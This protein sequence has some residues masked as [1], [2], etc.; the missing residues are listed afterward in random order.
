MLPKIFVKELG[1]KLLKMD[2]N[3]ENIL[4]TV[5][6]YKSLA[7]NPI[8]Q[9]VVVQDITCLQFLAYILDSPNEEVIEEAL[10][11]FK[12][13]IEDKSN[14][15]TLLSVFGVLEAL[16]S[17]A[18]RC[19]NDKLAATARELH[20]ELKGSDPTAI[21]TVPPIHGRSF[22]RWA[23]RNEDGI[24]TS[25]KLT[26]KTI[27]LHIHGLSPETRLSLEQAIV[28]LPGVVSLM[29]DIE[30]QR[31]VLR[32]RPFLE[33][34]TIAKA[35]TDTECLEAKLVSKNK[36]KQEILLP[37]GNK[38]LSPLEPKPSTSINELSRSESDPS[39]PDYLPEEEGE[40]PVK[41]NAV[42]LLGSLRQNASGW[43]H[44]AASFLHQSFYW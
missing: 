42:S 2:K 21:K 41:E 37:M 15:F 27:T 12:L 9:S 23:Q 25:Q 5:R 1:P 10:E 30:H 33:L 13:L 11:A 40:S 7:A 14:H 6:K 4:K 32:A 31:C 19:P 29:V 26:A 43:I 35:I 36:L 18:E 38:K 3:T 39:L 34:E 24:D 22:G 8:T 17:L 20:K 28:S 16:D 44:S